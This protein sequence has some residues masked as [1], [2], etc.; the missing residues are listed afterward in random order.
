MSE[1][2]LIIEHRVVLTGGFRTRLEALE[3]AAA[4]LIGRIAE[5][6]TQL[7]TLT[8]EQQE[9][10]LKAQASLDLATAVAEAMTDLRAA[11]AALQAS[12]ATAIPQAAF[13]AWK[14]ESDAAQAKMDAAIAKMTETL[15]PP[16]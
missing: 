2:N 6:A 16:A 11:F 5:M 13:D 9:T 14:V 10:N 12:A 3:T 7:E 4:Q 15:A 1:P 8:A